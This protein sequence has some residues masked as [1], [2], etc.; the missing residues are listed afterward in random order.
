MPDNIIHI[1]QV[2]NQFLH[3][4]FTVSHLQTYNKY[5]GK[6]KKWPG[7]IS[8]KTRLYNTNY[9]HIKLNKRINHPDKYQIIFKIY[10]E[11]YWKYRFWQVQY[12]L[13]SRLRY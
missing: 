2:N 10:S 4:S 13:I 9:Q 6:T 5:I 3:E 11:K 8:R 7:Q 1:R 12:I